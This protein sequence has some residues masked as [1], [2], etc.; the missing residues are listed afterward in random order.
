MRKTI[1]LILKLMDKDLENLDHLNDK[2]LEFVADRLAKLANNAIF[3]R[4]LRSGKNYAE[5]RQHPRVCA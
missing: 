4:D 5:R 2:Q 3:K 1:T